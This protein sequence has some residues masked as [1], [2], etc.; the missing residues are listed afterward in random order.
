MK[1]APILRKSPAGKP[2]SKTRIPK[3]R[4]AATGWVTAE[5]SGNLPLVKKGFLVPLEKRD[6]DRI[7]A[8]LNWAKG[9]RKG[10]QYGKLSSTFL[11]VFLSF[12]TCEIGLFFTPAPLYFHFFA[13]L[14]VCL[15]LALWIIFWSVNR[16]VGELERDFIGEAIDDLKHL[17]KKFLF[18]NSSS[19]D[20]HDEIPV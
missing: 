1:D 16:K 5:N 7:F 3:E 4:L 10:R 8:K 6:L 13:L 19:T 2:R 17:R 20:L 15:S 9:L 12:L 14:I 18:V 11:G